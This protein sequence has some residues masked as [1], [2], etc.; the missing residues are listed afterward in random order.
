[1]EKAEK[2]EQEL[3]EIAALFRQGAG[4]E[5]FPDGVTWADVDAALE[6]VGGEAVSDAV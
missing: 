2:T 3:R 1:M 6:Y 4:F 5:D